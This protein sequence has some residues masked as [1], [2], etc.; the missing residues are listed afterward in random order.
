MKKVSLVLLVVIVIGLLPVLAQAQF[1]PGTGEI[2]GYMIAE[3][4]TIAEH[5][6]GEEDDGIKGNRGLWFRRIYFTYNN[7]LS[8]AVKMRFR[9]EMNSSEYEATK[10]VPYVKDA[11]ID[12]KLGA[13]VNLKAGIL[14]PPIFTSLEKIWGYRSLEK[15]PLDLYKWTSSRDFAVGLYGGKIFQ[16]G[17]YFGQGSSNK[18]EVDNGKKIYLHMAYVDKGFN[19]ALNG[20]YEKRKEIITETLI[21]PYVTYSGDWGRVGVEYGHRAEKV[22]PEE[23]DEESYKYNLVSAF[24]VWTASKKIDLIF[25]YD[26]NW[27]NGYYENWKGSKVAYIPFADYAEPS[28]FIGAVSWN[29]AKN[30]WL[31]PNIKYATYADPKEDG[32][33]DEKPGNDLYLNVTLFFK[34]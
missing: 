13:G 7:K 4:Y 10:L 14:D 26:K 8:D 3:W 27:G 33:I 34:F 20:H 31:I 21:H 18:G 19:V 22:K 11:W 15:T 12:F 9:I 28:F 32:R 5:N 6:T 23:G 17:G 30:V 29:A 1:K 16:W 2:K 25:R 24:I